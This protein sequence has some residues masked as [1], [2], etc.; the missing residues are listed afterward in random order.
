MRITFVS[1]MKSASSEN[2]KSYLNEV[3]DLLTLDGSA[4]TGST[5][6][7]AYVVNINGPCNIS[8]LKLTFS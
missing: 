2:R 6:S 7:A 4:L 3:C 5:L 1:Y 8:A